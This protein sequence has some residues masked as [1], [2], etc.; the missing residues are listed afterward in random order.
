MISGTRVV[1]SHS[2]NSDPRKLDVSEIVIDPARWKKWH[3]RAV[4]TDGEKNLFVLFCSKLLG[5]PGG[6][7][8]VAEL[9]LLIILRAEVPG[10]VPLFGFLMNGLIE[11]LP[12]LPGTRPDDL[13]LFGR[14]TME[15]LA[16][17]QRL[18]AAGREVLRQA[19][20][21]FE[22]LGFFG[23]VIVIVA[24]NDQGDRRPGA[25]A[26]KGCQQLA[27]DA[28][29]PALHALSDEER[30]QLPHFAGMDSP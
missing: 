24:N 2:E 26:Q 18:V 17:C 14:A 16:G 1:R 11:P 23:D 22:E 20:M 30:P 25:L 5:D 7:D 27:L 13:R 12:P 19:D 29:L 6:G 3:V 28:E 10:A 8:M 21:R 4:E 15:R 9:R